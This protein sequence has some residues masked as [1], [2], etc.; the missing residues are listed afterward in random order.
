M[1]RLRQ[2][3]Q[4]NNVPDGNQLPVTLRKIHALVVQLYH[5]YNDIPGISLA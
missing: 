3:F 5:T 4:A 1:I 2:E